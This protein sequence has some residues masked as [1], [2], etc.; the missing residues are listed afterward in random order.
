M[1]GWL[2]KLELKQALRFS[3]GLGLCNKMGSRLSL[4]KLLFAS[5]LR[6]PSPF[7]SK[8]GH[9]PVCNYFVENWCCLIFCWKFMSSYILLK[10]EVIFYIDKNWDR[11]LFLEMHVI[12]YNV[13]NGGLFPFC[14]KFMLSSI[15]LKIEVVFYFVEN[16][17]RLLFCWEFRLS[18]ILL[19]KWDC[20][21]FVKIIK[22][23]FHFV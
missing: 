1:G 5:K 6:L 2:E 16:W 19:N 18:L 7:M 9:F 14:W 8:W 22:D 10:V 11:L 15:L 21:P 12:L 17:G 13:E 4:L 20:I 3:F 23:N